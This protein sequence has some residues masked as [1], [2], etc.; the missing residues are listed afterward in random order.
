MRT[1]IYRSQVHKLKWS[2][3]RVCETPLYMSISNANLRTLYVRK[4]QRTKHPALLEPL[5]TLFKTI[6]EEMV[7]KCCWTE[8]T[9]IWCMSQV[10][11]TH[12]VWCELFLKVIPSPVDLYIYHYVHFSVKQAVNKCQWMYM[13]RTFQW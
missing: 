5:T 9:H 7:C 8:Y 4:L 10:S 13:S 12:V 3:S 1:A 2:V 11:S 6:A